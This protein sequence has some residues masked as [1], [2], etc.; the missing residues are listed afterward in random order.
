MLT[1]ARRKECFCRIIGTLF[2]Q[3][4]QYIVVAVKNWEGG[5]IGHKYPVEKKEV[6][7]GDCCMVKSQCQCAMFLISIKEEFDRINIVDLIS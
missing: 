3:F 6:I 5:A 4:E 7:W 2:E 1:L